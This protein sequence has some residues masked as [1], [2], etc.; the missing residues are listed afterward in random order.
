MEIGTILLVLGAIVLIA[1]IVWALV[2]ANQGKKLMTPFIVMGVSGALM[3]VGLAITISMSVNN[4]YT[5]ND[6]GINDNLWNLDDDYDDFGDYDSDIIEFDTAPLSDTYDMELTQGMYIGGIDIAPGI[7]KVSALDKTMAVSSFYYNVDS[8]KMYSYYEWLGTS[9]YDDYAE[10]TIYVGSGGSLELE[11]SGSLRFESIEVYGKVTP[12][13][14]EGTEITLEFGD[15]KI[16]KHIDEGVYDV[17][18]VGDITKDV[19][20]YSG[21]DY[22]ITL[23]S[24]SEDS[25]VC[26]SSYKNVVLEFGEDLTIESY[27]KEG[28]VKFTPVKH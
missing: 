14:E 19:N 25:Y 3:I 24:D 15:Y 1:A 17:E 23:C 12:L 27:A 8:N 9:K 6:F 5:D 26:G 20:I 18:I 21:Y 2:W 28:K 11:G 7:Y 10:D 16:G 22:S 13:P 4:L